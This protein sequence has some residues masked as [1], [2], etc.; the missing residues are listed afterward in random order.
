MVN[1]TLF[2][3]KFGQDVEDTPH[4]LKQMLAVMHCQRN[5]NVFVTRK[6]SLIAYAS[7]YVFHFINIVVKIKITLPIIR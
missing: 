4:A 6:L 1:R 5:N 7:P 3:I 2:G